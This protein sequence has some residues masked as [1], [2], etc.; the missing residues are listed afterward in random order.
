MIEVQC[1]SESRFTFSSFASDSRAR[2][3]FS[4]VVN[5]NKGTGVFDFE[6]RNFEDIFSFFF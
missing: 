3:L 4:T 6:R 5:S 2:V 1:R